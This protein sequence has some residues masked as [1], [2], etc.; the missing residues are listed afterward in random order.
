M[1]SHQ[2]YRCHPG[3]VLGPLLALC[4][5]TEPACAAALSI[6]CCITQRHLATTDWLPLLDQARVALLIITVSPALGQPKLSWC[7]REGTGLVGPVV[8]LSG[9]EAP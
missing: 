4:S 2:G 9:G 3:Q 5:S 7:C 1:S 8:L 6:V